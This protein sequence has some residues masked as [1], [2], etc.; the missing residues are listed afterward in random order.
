MSQSPGLIVILDL[1]TVYPSLKSPTGILDKGGTY[2]ADPYQ[3]HSSRI[4]QLA[5]V[6]AGGEFDAH[7]Y[8]GFSFEKL[9][10]SSVQFLTPNEIEAFKTL[11]PDQ[12]L[13]SIWPRFCEWL[14]EM[15]GGTKTI[16]FVAQQANYSDEIVLAIEMARHGLKWPGGFTIHAVEALPSIQK[17][18]ELQ[19]LARHRSWQVSSVYRDFTGERPTRVHD[20]LEDAKCLLRNLQGCWALNLVGELGF[21]CSLNNLPILSDNVDNLGW[22]FWLTAPVVLGWN[23]RNLKDHRQSLWALTTMT[24]K[25][26]S[27][28][29]AEMVKTLEEEFDLYTI[30]DLM[31]AIK[32]DVLLKKNKLLEENWNLVKIEANYRY[33]R[34]ETG[35]HKPPK[36][37]TLDGEY[38]LSLVRIQ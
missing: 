14:I 10:E 37:R 30:A 24:R 32:N 27:Q 34:T 21:K 25:G 23:I 22:M 13:A 6:C 5:C 18:F 38:L 28:W 20:A 2:R 29:P 3:I 11:T 36:N 35:Y 12:G 8:P 17:S 33:G 19:D 1:E 4:R 15:T 9:S 26:Y 31:E 16:T 7:V